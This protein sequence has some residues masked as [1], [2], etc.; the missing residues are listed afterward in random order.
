VYC[1][2][3]LLAKNDTANQDVEQS[4]HYRPAVNVDNISGEHFLQVNENV[5]RPKVEHAFFALVSFVD[6][7]KGIYVRQQSGKPKQMGAYAS[8]VVRRRACEKDT[9]HRQ[10]KLRLFL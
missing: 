9:F 5:A 3:D 2:N 4:D 10:V 7:I 6:E 8:D 1:D